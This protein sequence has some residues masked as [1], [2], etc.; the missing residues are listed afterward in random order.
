MAHGVVAGVRL[1]CT[2]RTRAANGVAPNGPGH[3]AQASRHRRR[4]GRCTSACARQ[5]AS[6]DRLTLIVHVVSLAGDLDLV[7]VEDGLL[8][9]IE[10][11][12]YVYGT[13]VCGFERNLEPLRG[14][15]Y[16]VCPHIRGHLVR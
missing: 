2:S 10:N 4:P 11:T 15:F 14:Q 3:G 12:V 1:L 8:N 16:P 6:V 9:Y 5:T 7:G 13:R